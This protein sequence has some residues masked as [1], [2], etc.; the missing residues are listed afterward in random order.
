MIALLS[1]VQLGKPF[2]YQCVRPQA[3]E[4][5]FLDYGT[6]TPKLF[7][8]QPTLSSTCLSPWTDERLTLSP[9]DPLATL[10]YGTEVAGFPFFPTHSLSGV[11]Q[12][13]VKYA[14]KISELFQPYSD[15]P[16]TFSNGLSNMFRVETSKGT[17]IGY[18]ESFVVQGVQRW[19]SAKLVPNRF[20]TIDHL[21]LRSTA[22]DIPVSDL[23]AYLKAQDKVLKTMFDLGGRVVQAASID[24]GNAPSTREICYDGAYIRGQTSAQSALEVTASYTFEISCEDY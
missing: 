15:G 19:Q 10:E 3:S 9:S 1:Q 2:L 7:F 13:Q 16:W 21:G 22:E 6:V 8:Q 24:A 4:H 23:P 17:E 12:I 11:V 5:L 20:V 18:I 14:D